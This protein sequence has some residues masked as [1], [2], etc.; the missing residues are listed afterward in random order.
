MPGILYL[1]TNLILLR[2]PRHYHLH[3]PDAEAETKLVTYIKSLLVSNGIKI[4]VQLCPTPNSILF[5]SLIHLFI[6]LIP[7]AFIS[8]SFLHKISIY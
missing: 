6:L 1:Q 4:Q 5:Y 8:M 2:Y 3:F 7:F